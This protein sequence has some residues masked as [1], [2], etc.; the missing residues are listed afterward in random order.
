MTERALQKQICEYLKAKNIF[1]FA[2]LPPTR[3]TMISGARKY[4]TDL[5]IGIN[6]KGLFVELKDEQY[7]NAHK[8]RQKKQEEF[9]QEA[10]ENGFYA[11]KIT[12]LEQLIEI[13]SY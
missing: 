7:K 12:S 3:Q 1:H 10:R 2:I 5:F 6:G 4:L 13:L 8:D 11:Y 9:M